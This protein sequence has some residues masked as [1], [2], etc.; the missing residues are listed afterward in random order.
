MGGRV[1]GQGWWLKV[2]QVF[3]SLRFGPRAARF[4]NPQIRV[5]V[6]MID[7]KVF[8][9]RTGGQVQTGRGGGQQSPRESDLGSIS[10]EGSGNHNSWAPP[11]G[12]G[13]LECLCP[14]VPQSS[15]C[16]PMMRVMRKGGRFDSAGR[17]LP[18]HELNPGC[19]DFFTFRIWHEKLWTL[20]LAS[21]SPSDAVFFF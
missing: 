3:C 14:C 21:V 4:V 5:H 6:R 8:P 20:V 10:Q 2:S 16:P 15:E 19:R 1:S 13:E 11:I 18:P 9:G 12:T 7:Y 17:P